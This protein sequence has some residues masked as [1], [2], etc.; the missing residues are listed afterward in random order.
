MMINN[1]HLMVTIDCFW[2]NKVFFYQK[3]DDCI[4]ITFLF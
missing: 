4:I 1:R 2:Y 3:S